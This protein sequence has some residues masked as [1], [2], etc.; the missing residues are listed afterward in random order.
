[1][2]TTVGE[3]SKRASP[4]PKCGASDRRNLEYEIN[5]TPKAFF[6]RIITTAEPVIFD[7][8]AHKGESVKFFKDL[9]PSSTIYTFEPSPDVFLDLSEVASEYGN[10]YAFNIGC[11]DSDSSAVFYS[12]DITHLG[13][14]L[15]INKESSDSL[16]YAE[17]AKNEP[18]EVQ[19]RSLDSFCGERSVLHI[20]ILKIDTRGYEYEVLQGARGILKSTSCVSVEISLYDFYGKNAVSPLLNIERLMSE[21]GFAL[22]DIAKISKNPKSLRT[23]WIEAV[24]RKVKP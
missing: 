22:W 14:F 4:V 5:F 19:K 1:M 15:P 23:D 8:G 24:Y 21:S 18:V 6:D 13:G 11:G 10:V 3:E 20:D 9:Y 7:V 16:G 2:N 12:Q 17:K